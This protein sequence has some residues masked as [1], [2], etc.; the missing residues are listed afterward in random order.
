MTEYR[1]AAQLESHTVA[2]LADSLNGELI[3]PSDASYDEARALF[4][5]MIDRHP[6]LIAR[7]A[8]T[9]DVKKAL[10]FAREHNLELA[11]RGR[12]H[13]GGGLGSVDRGLV[14][15]LSLMN[16]VHVDAGAR[17]IRAQGGC[18]W[19][20]VDGAG[21]EV[22]LATPAGIISTTGVGGLTLGGGVGHLSRKCGLTIDNLL[23]ARMVL[24]DGTEAEASEIEN[25]DLFWAI[26][27]GGGNYGIVTEF[28]FRAHP[29]HTVYAGPTF[30]S[31]E[32]TPEIL[33]W[34]HGF[35]A[36][37]PRDLGGFFAFIQVPPVDMFP[38]A[39]HL[40]IVC[41][42][43]WCWAGAMDEAEAALA[44]VRAME[45]MLDGVGPMPYP[46]LQ[47]VFDP[48]YTPGHQWYW[49]ADFMN[50]MSDEAIALHHEHGKRL[51]SVLSSMHT[52]P[53]DGA[54]HDVG[55]SETAWAYRDS[56]YAQ[57]IVGVDP[58]PALADRLREWT[59]EYWE[60][61]HPHSAGGAYVN[62]MMDEGQERVMATYGDNYKRLV[63]V[64][65]R[66]DPDNVFHVNQNIR[67]ESS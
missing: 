19:A 9:A 52:Y 58:D 30:W 25:P 13:N 66:Y 20:E 41:G 8:D 23:R 17:T 65:N 55:A 34:Y 31:L 42:V 5:A 48:L 50:T 56:R 44:P 32:R 51:P 22:G 14:I 28:E 2:G 1:N 35:I 45:P 62:F 27:G 16:E 12:G 61:L 26:R 49:R 33:A 15:D 21:H 6:G 24:A 11:V 37:A 4:N 40:E 38:E 59:V 47:S 7:C 36:S 46:A 3:G 57:V 43:V 64:K 60:A 10:A 18:K 29:I 63:D 39:L 53:I 54:V 67:P